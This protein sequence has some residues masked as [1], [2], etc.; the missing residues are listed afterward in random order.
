MEDWDSYIE[1]TLD[2]LFLTYNNRRFT[3]ERKM[4]YP[5]RT[6]EETKEAKKNIK[7]N[8]E[9]AK[10]VLEQY[11]MTL[12]ASDVLG[13][14]IKKKVTFQFSRFNND[15]VIIDRALLEKYYKEWQGRTIGLMQSIVILFE[16]RIEKGKEMYGTIKCMQKQSKKDADFIIKYMPFSK[17]ERWFKRQILECDEDDIYFA[18]TDLVDFLDV[19]IDKYISEYVE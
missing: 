8:Q 12:L 9:G 3:G 16:A 19:S 4:G 11:R 7:I 2:E 1:E 17:L 6:K 5:I 10:Q 15:K 13:I 18:N 14:L